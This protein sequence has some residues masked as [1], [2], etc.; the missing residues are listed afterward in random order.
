MR[1]E[2]S[3]PTLTSNMPHETRPLNP[4]FA[5]IACERQEIL[6]SDSFCANL[7]GPGR[8]LLNSRTSKLLTRFHNYH[9]SG[10]NVFL[11]SNQKM[12]RSI[13][14]PAKECSCWGSNP[15]SSLCERDVIP[16]DH[17]SYYVIEFQSLAL[18]R[19]I[20]SH[21]AQLHNKKTNQNSIS[22][23]AS[24]KT[25]KL[26]SRSQLLYWL[27]DCKQKRPYNAAG[28]KKPSRS[29]R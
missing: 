7:R 1:K 24:T 3:H 28:L 19:T 22:R 14:H 16:L 8:L 12:C 13:C 20:E 9:S 4:C 29:S 23:K 5:V 26:Q 17:T 10:K 2:K 25:E 27:N 15:G 11:P 18:R 21:S 6:S